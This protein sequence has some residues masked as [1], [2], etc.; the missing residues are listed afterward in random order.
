MERSTTRISKELLAIPE[1]LSTAAF[2]VAGY[3][4]N[5]FPT[6]LSR[7]PVERIAFV[8]RLDNPLTLG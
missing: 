3:P 4:A 7:R 6:A 2:V 1:E 5:G 8:D